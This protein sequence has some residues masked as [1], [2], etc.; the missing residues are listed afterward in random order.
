VGRLERVHGGAVSLGQASSH[1]PGFLVKSSLMTA[2][3]RAIAEHAATLVEPGSAVAISAGTTTYELARCL[4]TV[5]D[6]TV[7]TNSVPVAQ[8]LHES[9]TPGQT[10]VLTGGLR[11]PSDALVG[12][13][14]VSALRNLHV[15]LL[16]LGAHGVDGRTGLTT[17]NLVEAETNR[18]LV[19]SARHVC[20]L[21]DSSK[22][23]T[24]GL[25]TFADLADV[26]LFVT[27]DAF[28]ERARDAA[29]ES[30]GSLEIVEA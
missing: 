11:T 7:V 23:G 29:R 25:S 22:W 1:E 17:P 9:S 13:V 18:A 12:P 4:R 8:L 26:D 5:P 21:A 3:K 19:A 20:L 15:D 28:P 14:A 2:E 30:V 10:V 16:F 6:I 27:D 24:I